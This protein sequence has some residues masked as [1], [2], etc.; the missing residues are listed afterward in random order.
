MV[1]ESFHSFKLMYPCCSF[2]RRKKTHPLVGLE[3]NYL[4]GENGS[5]FKLLN[6]TGNT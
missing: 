5:A 4:L 1:F 6:V 2:K 3:Q